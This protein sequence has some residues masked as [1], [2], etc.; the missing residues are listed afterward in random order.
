MIA[1]RGL[2]LDRF[3]KLGEI[4]V[5]N[6]GHD[7]PD[8]IDHIRAQGAGGQIRAIAQLRDRVAHA[9]LQGGLDRG[10]AA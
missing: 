1:H 4:G 8:H 3:G 7:Q 6:V 5:G 2:G 10:I 9:G